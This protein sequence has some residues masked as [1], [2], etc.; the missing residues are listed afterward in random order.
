[1]TSY[2]ESTAD[3]LKVAAVALKADVLP[4][5]EADGRYP[6]AMVANAL[7]IAARELELGPQAR[8][9]ERALIAA[10]FGDDPSAASLAEL[11]RRLCRELRGPD[12]P[13]ARE[14]GLRDLLRRVVEARLA[15][16]NPAYGRPPEGRP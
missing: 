2:L 13:P 10:F 3:L 16:S 1:M 12:L 5:V 14:A 4:H 11:R 6:A 9:E 15:I 7:A 8:A